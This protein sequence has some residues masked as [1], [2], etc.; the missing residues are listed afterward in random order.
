[1]TAGLLFLVAAAALI[2]AGTWLARAADSI[3]ER[4]GV[5]RVWVGTI[6]LAAATSLPELA[7]D[8]AA[9]RQGNPDLAAGDLFGSSMANMLILG[10]LDLTSPR[11]RVLRQVSVQHAMSASLAIVL[12]AIAG[13][14][15][16]ARQHPSFLGLG[17]FSV[18]LLVVYLGGARFAW[19]RR[20]REAGPRA[21]R[22]RGLLRPALTFAGAAA[23]IAVA[24]PTFASS[25]ASLAASTGAGQTFLGGWL[26]GLTTSAPELIASLASVRMGA[27]DLAVG[28]L[29]GSNAL[30]MALF[31]ALDVANGGSPVFAILDPAHA[32]TAILAILLTGVGLNAVL[33]RGERRSLPVDPA[34][35]GI[36][37]AYVAGISLLFL[38]TRPA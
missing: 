36:L 20:S 14:A 34:A 10:L 21:A 37:L 19:S 27:F 7:S 3:A 15:I 16:L 11:R 25:A 8:I 6:L 13:A 18:T 29:F 38:A 17:L 9:I 2:L 31:V 1:M 12:T 30:N 35:V 33:E 32:L 22:P 23:V 24:A 4:T 5:G 26:L 28:N